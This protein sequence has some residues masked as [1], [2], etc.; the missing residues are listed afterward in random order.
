MANIENYVYEKGILYY[1]DNGKVHSRVNV[2]KLLVIPRV[3]KEKI[4][5]ALHEEITSGVTN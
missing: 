2:R 1:L 4:M 5:L 3:L